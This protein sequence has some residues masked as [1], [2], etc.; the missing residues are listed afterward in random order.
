MV[1]MEEMICK[2]YVIAKFQCFSSDAI[3]R[4]REIVGLIPGKTT[5]GYSHC[6]ASS[7]VSEFRANADKYGNE[8]S[9]N[10]TIFYRVLK[11][12]VMQLLL[13]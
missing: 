2:L 3:T 5:G 4:A 10:L 6:Q 7:I 13:E 12:C 11:G 9:S 8:R 1:L